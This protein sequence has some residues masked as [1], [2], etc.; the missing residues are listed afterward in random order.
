LLTPS[1]AK[2]TRTLALTAGSDSCHRR[3][4]SG[5][6]KPLITSCTS[7][8]RAL[9]VA[10]PHALTVSQPCGEYGGLFARAS[11]FRWPINGRGFDDSIWTYGYRFVTESTSRGQS[12][13]L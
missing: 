10:Y 7:S 2:T 4:I 9:Q 13:L 1:L 3:A 12:A 5:A 8:T 6:L 11:A